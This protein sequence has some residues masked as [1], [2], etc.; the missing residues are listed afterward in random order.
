MIVANCLESTFLTKVNSADLESSSGLAKT[1]ILIPYSETDRPPSFWFNQSTFEEYIANSSSPIFVENP[2]SSTRPSTGILYS[3]KSGSINPTSPASC[4]NVISFCTV[5]EVNTR[6]AERSTVVEFS[7]F[8]VTVSEAFPLSPERGDTESQSAEQEAFH[9]RALVKEKTVV[10][11]TPALITMSPLFSMAKP[12][13]NSLSE[14]AITR[15]KHK[16]NRKKDFIF[17]SVVYL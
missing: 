12:G 3:D 8:V 14:Q 10:E 1:F 17:M 2:I 5:P 4:V 13:A 16:K 7:L 15:K 11:P 9:S 6:V